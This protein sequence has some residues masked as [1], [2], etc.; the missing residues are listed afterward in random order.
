[1]LYDMAF[2]IE[3]I[4]SM[5]NVIHH[6]VFN[7]LDI[8]MVHGFL[9]VAAGQGV[10]HEFFLSTESALRDSSCSTVTSSWPMMVTSYY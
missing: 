1:M 4:A 6:R 3:T 10:D 7:P 8:V 2:R 5:S 9:A